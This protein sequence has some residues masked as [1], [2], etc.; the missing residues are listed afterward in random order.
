MVVPPVAVWQY[1]L[2]D[3]AYNETAWQ[4][5]IHHDGAPADRRSYQGGGWI[6][7]VLNELGRDGW[8]L[9]ERSATGTGGHPNV[10]AWQLIFKRSIS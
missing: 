9:A 8:E 7:D 4:V 5:S 10:N 2:V 3:A 6:M 1:A